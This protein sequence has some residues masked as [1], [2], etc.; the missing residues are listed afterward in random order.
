M[1]S[2]GRHAINHSPNE[3]GWRRQ[4]LCFTSRT[5]LGRSQSLEIMAEVSPCQVQTAGSSGKDKPGAKGD[6]STGSVLTS[7]VT[8]HGV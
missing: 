8:A 6:P 3:R 5:T 7:E 4:C 1:L 2:R